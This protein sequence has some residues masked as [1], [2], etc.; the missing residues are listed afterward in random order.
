[1]TLSGMANVVEN[2]QNPPPVS[3]LPS[4]DSA[5]VTPSVVSPVIR[6]LKTVIPKSKS[7][8][9]SCFLAR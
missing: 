6:P 3:T 9:L 5:A 8:G 1:M 7:A 2:E 4:V